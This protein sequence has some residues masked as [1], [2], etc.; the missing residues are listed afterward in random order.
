M[1]G[2][3]PEKRECDWLRE[4]CPNDSVANGQPTGRKTRKVEKD[5]RPRQHYKSLQASLQSNNGTSLVECG[6]WI[7]FE[8]WC[9]REFGDEICYFETVGDMGEVMENTKDKV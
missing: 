4:G 9:Y 1:I 5:I 2:Q 6:F 7:E 3:R 8:P